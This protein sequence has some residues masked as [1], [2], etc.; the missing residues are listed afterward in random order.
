LR[1]F[2]VLFEVGS[3][4]PSLLERRVATPEEDDALSAAAH[5]TVERLA[6]R[7]LETRIV[8]ERLNRR[9]IDLIPLPE[10]SDPPKAKIAALLRTV[11][12]AQTA[13]VALRLSD[14]SIGFCEMPVGNGP[15]PVVPEP[16]TIALFG[17]GLAPLAGLIRRRII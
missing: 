15:C 7:G 4:G 13:V 17:L 14:E 10:W 3:E 5:D 9:K 12:G 6:A 1:G 2:F 11:D 16:G 8:S